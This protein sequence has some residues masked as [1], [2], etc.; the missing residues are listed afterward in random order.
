LVGT[1]ST[2]V[3]FAEHIFATGGAKLFHLCANALIVRWYPASRKSF[4]SRAAAAATP[5][6]SSRSKMMLAR[7]M[8]RAPMV[9]DRDRRRSSLT[10]SGAACSRLIG[11]AIPA[12]LPANHSARQILVDICDAGH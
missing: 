5:T 6:P 12:I 8:S 7:S 4:F 10:T 1:T 3:R 11:R 2:L 9:V